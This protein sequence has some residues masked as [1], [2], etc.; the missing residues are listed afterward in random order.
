MVRLSATLARGDD[1]SALATVLV[2]IVVLSTIAASVLAASA[3]QTRLIRQDAFRLQ[4]EY[5]AEAGVALAMEQMDGTVAFW[6]GEPAAEDARIGQRFEISAT[7]T[8]TVEAAPFAGFIYVRSAGMDRGKQSVIYTTVGGRPPHVFDHAVWVGDPES[9]LIATGRSVVAGSIVTGSLG[10]QEQ[11]IRGVPF[12]GRLQGAQIAADSVYLPF[13]DA[14]RIVSDIERLHRITA[15]DA[16]SVHIVGRRP[17]PIV[18]IPDGGDVQ[19]AVE[20]LNGSAI[21]LAADSSLRI[22]DLEVLPRGSIVISGGSIEISGHLSADD[23]IVAARQDVWIGGGTTL[24]GQFIAGRDVVIADDAYLAY[25]SL[26]LSFGRSPTEEK[27]VGIRISDRAR[28]DGSVVLPADP[29]YSAD[30]FGSDRRLVRIDAGT[31]VR[32]AVYSDAAVEL[33]G[34]VHGT[35]CTRAFYFYAAPSHYT[36]WLKDATIDHASRPRAFA[37]PVGFEEVLVPDLAALRHD[38]RHRQYDE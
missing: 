5:A 6:A 37:L 2:L 10:V 13:F 19:R 1:G 26:V 15:S 11:M 32:G 35:V 18:R 24:S 3:L 23:I 29:Q 14:G 33:H 4:S 38:A 7:S 9:G 20:A 21:A 31:L 30:P 12:S 8:A 28:V 34:S 36:N 27:W 25:P 22:A 16:D 17:L